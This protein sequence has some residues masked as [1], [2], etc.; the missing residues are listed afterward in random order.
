MQHKFQRALETLLGG[1]DPDT[2]NALFSNV[3]CS[4]DE[5]ARVDIDSNVFTV[6]IGNRETG[7]ITQ[8]HKFSCLVS[9]E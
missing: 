3:L 4:E 1:Q 9:C 2:V 8:T 6:E 5:F 7:E